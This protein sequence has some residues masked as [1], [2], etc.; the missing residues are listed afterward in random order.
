M[1]YSIQPLPFKIGFHAVLL[2]LR[3]F[4]ILISCAFCGWILTKGL[5]KSARFL[6]MLGF[7]FALWTQVN[8][9]AGAGTAARAFLFSH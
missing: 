9:G 5:P 6:A 7:T 8:T 1:S 4:L 3:G 2:V